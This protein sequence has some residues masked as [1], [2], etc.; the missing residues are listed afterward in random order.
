MG[1]HSISSLAISRLPPDPISRAP[2]TA[3]VRPRE[4][5]GGEAADGRRQPQTAAETVKGL[6]L[7]TFIAGTMLRQPLRS[8]AILCG[9]SDPIGRGRGEAADG[10]REP[11]K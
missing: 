9:Y 4:Y 2:F 1:S 10:R 11:P 5:P 7:A 3:D 6:V 8:S